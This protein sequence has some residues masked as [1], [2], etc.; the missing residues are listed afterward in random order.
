MLGLNRIRIVDVAVGV[1]FHS[2]EAGFLL[3]Y[4]RAWHGYSFPS[5]K[6]RKIEAGPDFAAREAFREATGL[7]LHHMTTQP[8]FYSEIERESQRTGQVTRYRYHGFEIQPGIDFAAH[9]IPT[10]PACKLLYLPIERFPAAD[11]VTWT[12][13]HVVAELMENQHVALAAVVRETPA[14]REYL[15]IR[16]PSYRGYFPIASRIRSDVRP[17]AQAREGFRHDTGYQA[18]TEAG[19][20][21]QATDRHHSPR[22]GCTR[23]FIYHTTRLTLPRVNLLEPDNILEQT[24]ERNGVLWR[25]VPDA[26]LDDPSG[27]G[28]SST[29]AVIR[30]VLRRL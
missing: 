5:R 3:A 13:Q 22:F 24:L 1:Y 4:N 28:L 10:G 12:A 20:P 11:L 21:V 18:A 29:I 27:N 15:M 6:V 26:E 19:E 8:L 25:W 9:G 2:S 7:P 14:G 16:Y 17:R 23:D 30:D